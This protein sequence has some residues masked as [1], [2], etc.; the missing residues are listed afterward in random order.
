MDRET[1]ILGTAQPLTHDIVDAPIM[2][3]QLWIWDPPPTAFVH[4]LTSPKT[5]CYFP[6]NLSYDKGHHI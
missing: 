1:A 2:E 4:L 3:M 5:L 6:Y